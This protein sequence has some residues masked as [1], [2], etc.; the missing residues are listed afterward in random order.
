M[1]TK[2]AFAVVIVLFLSAPAS[3]N[4]GRVDAT[5]VSDTALVMAQLYV[6]EAGWRSPRDYAAIHHSI[7]EGARRRGVTVEK[8]ARDYGSIFKTDS[9]RA[10]WVLGLNG[11]MT[12]P[13]GWPDDVSWERYG[14]PRWARVLMESQINEVF[15]PTNPCRGVPRHWGG[16]TLARDRARARRAIAAGRWIPLQCGPTINGYYATR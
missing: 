13:E 4:S 2:T 8:Q 15:M 7:T 9:S 16:R 10:T 1:S 14:R 3:A 12:E 6:A 11:E 5:L